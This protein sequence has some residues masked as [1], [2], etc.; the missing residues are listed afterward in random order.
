MHF[1]ISAL[2]TN[3]Y[4]D[5]L[6]TNNCRTIFLIV[7]IWFLSIFFYLYHVF[8]HLFHP[9]DTKFLI[10]SLR[11]QVLCLPTWFRAS[12]PHTGPITTLFSMV[13]SAW[14]FSIT[15]CHHIATRIDRF[16]AYQRP[17][18]KYGFL[19][20][21]SGASKLSLRIPT[22]PLSPWFTSWPFSLPLLHSYLHC[23]VLL[24]PLSTS[25]HSTT[26]LPLKFPQTGHLSFSEYK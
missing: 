6:I 18:K 11:F 26:C 5:F 14:L 24:G 25:L 15:F 12:L 9:S 4:L 13:H 23:C 20:F 8:I 19:V 2:S 22:S 1:I 16:L 10:I 21:T 3:S 7:E 17:I